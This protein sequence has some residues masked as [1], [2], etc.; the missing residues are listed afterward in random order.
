MENDR[1]Y[2]EAGQKQP[3]QYCADMGLRGE[4]EK[5]KT[6]T[7]MDKERDEQA[8]DPGTKCGQ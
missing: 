6:K 8:G 7:D 4:T 3:L 2:Y 5:D 1:T